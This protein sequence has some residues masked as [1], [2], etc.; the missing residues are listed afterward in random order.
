MHGIRR[1][2]AEGVAERVRKRWIVSATCDPDIRCA[3]EAGGRLTCL[4]AAKRA[5]LWTP[6]HDAIHLAVPPTAARVD[7]IGLRVHWSRGPAPVPAG[8]V[9]DS[10]IN[11]LFHVAR[12]V[13]PL[14]ALAV[15]ESAVRSRA[16]DPL[17]LKRVEWRS[18]A[19]RRLAAESSDLSD[20]GIE[21]RFLILMRTSGIT[22]R[23]QVR[24]VG[25]HVDGL[26]GRRLVVQLD[27]FAHHQAADRRRDIRHDADLVL[28]GFTVLRF[29]YYQV[30]FQP[31]AVVAAVQ[32]A[33]A[34]GLHR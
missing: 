8:S 34:Q 24:L 17:V 16:V 32:M 2:V 14:E 29:D 25:H 15:W 20:S 18:E 11:V 30:L 7:R 19:A 23:Q 6:D 5:G 4:T 10:L 21:T 26:I 27:G 33:I 13:P 31:D 3:V 22:V 1:A 28:R 12:C 9:T